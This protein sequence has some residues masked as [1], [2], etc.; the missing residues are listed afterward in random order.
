M[1]FQWKVSALVLAV[2][3]VTATSIIWK[4]QSLVVADK[5]SFVADSSIKQI[6]PIKRLVDVK[7]D[8]AQRELVRFA[9]SRAVNGPGRETDFGAFDIISLIESSGGAPSATWIERGSSARAESWPAK[10]EL[11]LLKSLPFARVRDGQ[12]YWARVADA[13]GT[14]VFALVVSVE[15]KTYADTTGTTAANLPDAVGT[16]AP[17]KNTRAYIVG[18]TTQNPLAA[19]TEDFIGSSNNVY[20]VDDRGY[21]AS[22]VDKSYNGALFT[23]D[24]IVGEIVK[25]QKTLGTGRYEDLESRPVIGHFEKIEDSNLTAIISTPVRAA[26]MGADDH[27]QTAIFTALAVALVAAIA[28]WFAAGLLAPTSNGT[29]YDL[30]TRALPRTFTDDDEE[31]APQV[32]RATHSSPSL[33]S[34]PMT[35]PPIVVPMKDDVK[36]DASLQNERKLAYEAFQQGLAK[37]M[38]EPLL[39]ILGHAQLIRANT[40][41]DEKIEAHVESIERDARSARES[42]DRLRLFEEAD[43]PLDPDD[44]FD[45]DDVIAR[46]LEA[47]DIDLQA[48]GIAVERGIASLPRLRGRASD[49]GA[50]LAHLVDNAIEA[51][52]DRPVRRLK[53]KTEIRGE[54]AVLSVADTGIGMPRDVRNRAFE[55]FF[56]NFESPFRMGLGLAFVHA[57][58]HRADANCEIDSTPGEGT[59]VSLKFPLP[60]TREEAS[61]PPPTAELEPAKSIPARPS[62]PAP[63][64][65]RVPPPMSMASS[66]SNEDDDDAFQ[67]VG[68]PKLTLGGRSPVEGELPLPPMPYPKLER[69]ADEPMQV[70]VEE[71]STALEAQATSENSV[72]HQFGEA[73]SVRAQ[74]ATPAP[75]PSEPEAVVESDESQERH[76]AESRDAESRDAIAAPK[77][78][79]VRIRPPRTRGPS[80]QA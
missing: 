5:L 44:M 46:T 73:T 79:R 62:T 51:L 11:T 29:V 23:E 13:R 38:R 59:V 34:F 64:I 55:P 21:V 78:F 10:H 22:H 43:V 61:L 25:A 68:S 76:E 77:P 39:S 58:A 4:T 17:A 1:R 27:L 14:A 48:A 69:E 56:K 50:A 65:P 40:V 72:I 35:P 18:F 12:R 52:R 16:S 74:I 71:A 8:D 20:I 80:S 57:A 53:I 42:L 37:Q 33:P 66:T 67:V 19:I 15:V 3:F 49:F 24:P 30:G 9:A 2:V 26:T 60:V 6:A 31:L 36:N 45:L 70:A 28:A 75:Q 32:L 63:A 41:G 47:K 54:S 7:L